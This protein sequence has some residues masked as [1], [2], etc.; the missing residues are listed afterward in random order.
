MPLA[1]W[2]G[3][4]A[5]LQNQTP[6]EASRAVQ[7]DVR[8]LGVSGELCMSVPVDVGRRHLGSTTRLVSSRLVSARFGSAQ[9]DLAPL[10]WSKLM[11]L[12][13]RLTWNYDF[14]TQNASIKCEEE[15]QVKF[16][17]ICLASGSKWRQA[18]PECL[19]WHSFVFYTLANVDILALVFHMSQLEK[20]DSWRPA[21]VQ[22]GQ[23]ESASSPL[24]VW[25]IF[26][27]R[28][29]KKTCLEGF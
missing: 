11:L 19:A 15:L 26:K 17:S 8:S 1:L 4:W 23:R 10:G 3:L 22:R 20:W 9:L 25:L 6:P 27:L 29:N 12:C 2:A 28:T 13:M 5:S 16:P 21:T 18:E 14:T 24:L 7:L